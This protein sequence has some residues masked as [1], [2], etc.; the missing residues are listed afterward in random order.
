[1]LGMDAMS[2]R[3][4]R[5]ILVLAYEISSRVKLGHRN[6]KGEGTT[7][8]N[9]IHIGSQIPV[10]TPLT[11]VSGGRCLDDTTIFKNKDVYASDHVKGHPL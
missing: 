6:P 11:H 5:E 4:L 2:I 3:H 7:W 9:S 8:H 1:M 10:R